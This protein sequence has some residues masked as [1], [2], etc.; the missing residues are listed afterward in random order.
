MYDCQQD[1]YAEFSDADFVAHRPRPL[2]G[3]VRITHSG[4]W[5]PALEALIARIESLGYT[6]EHLTQKIVLTHVSFEHALYL[7]RIFG[8]QYCVSAD[9]VAS[10]PSRLAL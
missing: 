6:P 1:V 2:S 3:T 5:S 9:F 7:N 10:R 8:E 4:E